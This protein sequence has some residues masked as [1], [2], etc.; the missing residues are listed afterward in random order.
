MFIK[1]N[2]VI[3]WVSTIMSLS[4]F[5]LLCVSLSYTHE[6]AH[7][8]FSCFLFLKSGQTAK[9]CS[10]T[11]DACLVVTDLLVAVEEYSGCEDVIQKKNPLYCH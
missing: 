7:K 6:L 2:P 5:P 3:P 8:H 10:P 9:I 11:I 4:L 1:M